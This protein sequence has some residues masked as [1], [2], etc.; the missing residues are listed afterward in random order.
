M[1]GPTVDGNRIGEEVDES[2]RKLLFKLGGS[3][4]A[5]LPPPPMYGETPSFMVPPVQT[6]PLNEGGIKCSGM[7]PALELDES[8]QF[9][10]VKLDG[11]EC[12]F[13]MGDQSMRWSEVNSLVCSNTTV[14]SSSQGMQQYCL[15]EEPVDLGMQ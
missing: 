10:Q 8:F 13:G 14:A 6:A 2:I 15:V 12:F 7:L 5:A 9:N 11:L 1:P 4:F 3:P